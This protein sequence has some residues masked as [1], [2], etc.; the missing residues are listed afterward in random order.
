MQR[1]GENLGSAHSDDD[2]SVLLS[3]LER[4]NAPEDFERQVRQ[5][6]AANETPAPFDRAV[7]LLGLKFAAPMLLLAMVGAFLIYFNSKTPDV[8]ELPEV[9]DPFIANK[10]DVPTGANDNGAV[11]S[12]HK[13]N[14]GVVNGRN[15]NNSSTTPTIRNGNLRDMNLSRTEDI[16]VDQAPEPIYPP[17]INPNQ[18]I[19]PPTNTSGGS[20]SPD[21][22]LAILGIKSLCSPVNCKVVGVQSQSVGEKAGLIV[23]DVVEAIDDRPIGSTHFSSGAISVSSLR[24]NRDGKIVTVNLKSR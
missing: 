7:L 3:S 6:I 16:T 2:V 14:A 21:S 18:K 10:K 15:L 11:A 19:V 24:V 4:V 13:S 5:R 8:T 9:I 20:I 22:I 1:E 12:T 23:G 17:G